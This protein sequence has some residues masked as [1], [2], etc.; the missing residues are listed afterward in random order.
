MDV[1]QKKFEKMT[2]TPVK[3]LVLR[4][5]VPTILSMLVSTF[6]NM[7]DTFFVGKLENDS[8][9][10]AV[11]VVFSIMAVIQAVGF[12]FGHG[13][14]NF[15]SREL[16][17]KHVSEAETMVSVGFFSALFAGFL[18]AILGLLFQ[19]P[20]AR[21]LGATDTILPYAVE[22]MRL[23]LC[24]APYMTAALVLNNQLR[25]QGNALYAMLGIVS[26]AVLNIGLDPLFIFVFD[27]GIGGA[28]WATIIS[29]L[30]SF[31]LL[32]I[33]VQRSDTLKIRFRRFRLQGIYFR[34]IL[35]GGTPS[36]CR[37]GLA[38]VATI[39]LN[40]MAGGYGDAAVAAFSVVQRITMFASSALIGF[41]QGFQPVCGF[42]W[43]A[44][45]YRRVR[46][47][48]WFCVWVSTAFLA[49]VAALGIAFA[50]T[51]VGWFRDAEEVKR[52]GSAALRAQLALFP[53][54]GWVTLC[55]MMLQNIGRVFRA[56]LVAMAR[57][58]LAFIPIVLLLPSLFE[59]NGLI[60]SQPAADLVAFG[61][62]LPVQIPVLR[63]MNRKIREES[64]MTAQ[65]MGN[66]DKN[67]Q[68][69]P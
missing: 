64:I 8:I 35:N 5:A 27:M 34:N 6:Y 57:Q 7:A 12:F 50:P 42:N 46:E 63:E 20:L 61:I 26:G 29:Q 14:G 47:A 49:F 4:L 25:F 48:F 2:Q 66:Y 19:E 45:K 17:K 54:L 56:S 30:V 41:G 28:A 18:I 15:V 36:L 40:H 67:V 22:Y 3:P 11:G 44:G 37:Q 9:T 39:C 10:G 65:N 68:M 51:V 69:I 23:I 43:G 33:G 62:T 59:I 21:L 13:S 55:N 32:F 24:G 58:G 1:Q 53:L 38:S 60:W 52:I 31:V 16:G